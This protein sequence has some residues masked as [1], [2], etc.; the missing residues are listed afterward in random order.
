MPLVI[1]RPLHNIFL[2]LGLPGI[3]VSG[4]L[5]YKTISFLKS[6]ER[7]EGIV[8][9][10]K[11]DQMSGNGGVKYWPVFKFTTKKNQEITCR[12]VSYGSTSPDYA[13]GKNVIIAY[14]PIDPSKASV[15]AYFNLFGLNLIILSVSIALI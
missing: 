3:F 8:T 4:F 11:T 5:F 15:I 2:I 13:V 6:S 10:L 14:D 1:K 9:E 7:A 12:C